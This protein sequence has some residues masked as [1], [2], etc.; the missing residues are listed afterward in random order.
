[1]LFQAV[2]PACTCWKIGHNEGMLR[3]CFLVCDPEH[4]GSIST[5]KLVIETAKLNV[6]TAYSGM[7]AIETL[8]FFPAVSGAVLDAGIKDMPCDEVVR[9]IKALRPQLTVIVVGAIDPGACGG[10]D[11]FLRSFEPQRLLDLLKMLEPEKMSAI[12]AHDKAMNERL[13]RGIAE[14]R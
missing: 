4:A 14:D 11:H 13:E 2:G 10:A 7:E 1:M 3:P 9:Q 8:K 5:R 6:I 12:A